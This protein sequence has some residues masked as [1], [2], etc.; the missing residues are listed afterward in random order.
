MTLN[1][2]AT[3]TGQQPVRQTTIN[4]T[5]DLIAV[6]EILKDHRLVGKSAAEKALIQLQNQLQ[7]AP[8]FR[9]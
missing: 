2:A 6:K 3:D 1:C 4:A 9:K 7:A 5:G 8:E